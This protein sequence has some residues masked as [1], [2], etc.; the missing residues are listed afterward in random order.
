[1]SFLA[2]TTFASAEITGKI[3]SCSGWQLNRF[4]ELKQFLVGGE[5]GYYHGVEV[6][7]IHGKEAIL[8]VYNESKIQ[9]TIKLS[10]LK[11]RGEMHNLMRAKGFVRKSDDEVYEIKEEVFWA[12]ERNAP[13]N[14]YFELLD[15]P[16]IIIP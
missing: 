16:A 5:A 11:D 8:T 15:Q 9:E 1:M 10:E 3:V 7:F 2:A 13:K 6:N 12:A 14:G 4:P